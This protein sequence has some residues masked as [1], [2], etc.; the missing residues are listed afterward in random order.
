MDGFLT[1]RQQFESARLKHT[2]AISRAQ[3]SRLPVY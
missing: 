3:S 2:F 1:L